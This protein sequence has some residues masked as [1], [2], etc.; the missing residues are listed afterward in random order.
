[1][2]NRSVVLLT[3]A[4]GFVGTQV[5]RRLLADTTCSLVALVRA[6]DQAAA[7]RRL[8]RAWWDWP[9][10]VAAIGSRVE[11]L[12]GDVCRPGLGLADATLGALTP[13]V[14]HVIHAAADLRLEAPIE[15]LR[16]TNVAGTQHVLDLAHTVQAETSLSTP[17]SRHCSKMLPVIIRLS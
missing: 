11:P 4:T 7:A 1:M 13:R 10:L 2:A 5:A 15:E 12:A 16:R 14:T 6:D 3:G 17:A 8:E 9:D